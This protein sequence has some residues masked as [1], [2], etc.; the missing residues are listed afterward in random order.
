M[1]HLKTLE[2][3]FSD[4]VKDIFR[5]DI[6]YVNK[7][8]YNYPD[9]FSRFFKRDDIVVSIKKS[10]YTHFKV[11]DKFKILRMEGQ[12]AKVKSLSDN[13]IFTVG[14]DYLLSEKDLEDYK[15]YI[16]LTKDINKYN[17]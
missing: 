2:A 6:Y 16:E 8:D 11:G 1:N 9:G 14:L 13:K 17:L 4:K 12:N 7:D 15:K 5:N 3:F 10:G